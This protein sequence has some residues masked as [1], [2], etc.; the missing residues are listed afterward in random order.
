MK[1]KCAA[2]QHD[3]KIWE[4]RNHADVIG[5][6]IGG[7]VPAPILNCDQGFVTECGLFVDRKQAALIAVKAGQIEKLTW[8]PLLYSEDLL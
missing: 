6:M 4:G 3:G 1:I 5:D 7:G 8:P 2:I